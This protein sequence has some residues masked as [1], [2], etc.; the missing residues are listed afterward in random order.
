[1]KPFVPIILL[2]AL[3]PIG[4]GGGDG[5]V[6]IS[7]EVTFQGQPVEDGM[8]Q[9]VPAGGSGG[10][11][12]GAPVVEG[13]YSIP[14]TGGPPAGPY[15]VEVSAFEEVRK[16]TEEE[17]GGAF[18]GRDPSEFGVSADELVIRE[19][20]IPESY[21]SSS[22]LTVTIPDQSSFEYDVQIP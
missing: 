13:R 2:A 7:G 19:N 8:I 12:A 6:A 1:M 15:R 14:R 9:F 21:N 4:C 18:F 20:V 10:R 3:V 16:Q 22:K 17:I 5:G 11:S